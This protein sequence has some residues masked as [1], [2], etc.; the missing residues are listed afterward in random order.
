MER[1]PKIK[2]VEPLEGKRLLVTFQNNIKKIY[3]C[4]PLIEEEIF[5]PLKDDSL[6]R[7]VKIDQGGYGI[8]WTDEIDLSESEIWVNG[9]LADQSLHQ[10][11]LKKTNEAIL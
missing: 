2:S 10:T 8:I 4:N 5:T 11:S 6:F 3:D 7:S 1:F 9:L